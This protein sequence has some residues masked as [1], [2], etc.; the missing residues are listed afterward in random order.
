MTRTLSRLLVALIAVLALG[1]SMTACISS[2]GGTAASDPN[3]VKVGTLRG[4]PH[5][6]QPYFME[7]FAPEGTKYEIVL[8]DSSPDMKNAL[9]SGSIDY[10]VMG[11]PSVI[12]AVA[13]GQ[14]LRMV[15]SAANGGSGFVGK[16]EIASVKDL[17]GK[18]IG[19][20]AGASQELLLR[21]TLQANGLD[22]SRDVQL[23]NLAF[24][25]MATAYKSGQIDAFLSAETAPSIV[26]QSGAKQITSPYETAIGGV[27]IVFATTGTVTGKDPKLAQAVVDSFTKAVDHMNANHAAWVDG[28]VSTFGVDRTVTE[29]AI[30]N[31]TPRW[32]LDTAYRAQVGALAEQM[33][34]FD[35]LSGVPDMAKVFDT[36]FVDAIQAAR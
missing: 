7:Q 14:D 9:A 4:Q 31:I 25:D 26:M 16:S 5:L 32:Q 35:Q 34:A 12:A 22:P 15:A 2:P 23:V 20:P 8:F 13:A 6:Y 3:A 36:T 10:A 24:S 29:T 21:L 17:K 33:V 28:L 27:N 19:F 18:K 1:S 30:K 11:A